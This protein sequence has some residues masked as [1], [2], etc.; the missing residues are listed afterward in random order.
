MN[1]SSYPK[2]VLISDVCILRCVSW[3]VCAC[4]SVFC[5]CSAA[6]CCL[7]S[8]P[9]ANTRGSPTKTFS[10]WYDPFMHIW[11]LHLQHPY[12]FFFSTASHLL[13]C[14]HICLRMC[15]FVCWWR[16]RRPCKQVGGFRCCWLRR[17]SQTWSTN[18]NSYPIISSS[19]PLPLCSSCFSER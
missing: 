11:L 2:S 18:P 12:S 16:H 13:H 4:V 15:W 6:W 19:S 3:P 8:P 1:P 7:C 5:W 14:I 17:K 10:S 9:S